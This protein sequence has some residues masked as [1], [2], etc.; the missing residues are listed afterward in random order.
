MKSLYIILAFTLLMVVLSFSVKAAESSSV[1]TD[2]YY[3]RPN[4]IYLSVQVI[5]QAGYTF[6]LATI[7]THR[8]QG[9]AITQVYKRADFRSQRRIHPQPVPCS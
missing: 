2:E 9:V 3:H 8:G 1:D 7:G 6:I 4:K 5:C